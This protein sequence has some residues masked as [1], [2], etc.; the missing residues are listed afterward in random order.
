MGMTENQLS[1]VRY[2]AENNMEKAKMAAEML[3]SKK[4]KVIL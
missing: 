2:V 4:E 3:I 1:L